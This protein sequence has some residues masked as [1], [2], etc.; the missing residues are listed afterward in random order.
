[1]RLFALAV[2]ALLVTGL[3]VAQP[4]SASPRIP[5]CFE[6]HIDTVEQPTGAFN[7][8]L[9]VSLRK[10]RQALKQPV[11]P[12]P[13]V[14]ALDRQPD[15]RVETREK[16]KVEEL[17]RTLDF[18]SGPTPGGGIYAAEQQRLLVPPVDNPLAQPYAAFSQGELTTILAE[19][20]VGKYLVAKV[21]SVISRERRERAEA[22]ARREVEDA[23]ARHA[24]PRRQPHALDVNVKEVVH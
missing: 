2:A 20:L 14:D 9:P 11:A 13:L 4:P 17:M 1:M 12:R 3:A 6:W 16:Q 19:N 21:A 8:E 5:T 22:A 23:I 7:F 24:G 15:F 10:I 18:R